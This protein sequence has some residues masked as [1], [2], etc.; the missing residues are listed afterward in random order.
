MH[1]LYGF[2]SIFDIVLCVEYLTFVSTSLLHNNFN[3]AL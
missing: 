1:I 3:S 2:K